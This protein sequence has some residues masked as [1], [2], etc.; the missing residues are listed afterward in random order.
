MPAIK[1]RDVNFLGLRDSILC[2]ECE[3]ISYNNT[4]KCL[5]CG[6]TAVLSLS[7]VLGG[8][9]QG[10]Q[11][12]RIVT[13][14]TQRNVVEFRGS[15]PVLRPPVPITGPWPS[16][17][18]A[19]STPVHSAMKLVVERGY[20]LSR[21][22]GIAIAAI[23]RGRMLCEA[24]QGELAPPLGAEIRAGISALS[25]RSRR[26]LRCDVAADDQRVDA[27]SCRA[28]GINS[29]VAAPIANLDR[30]FGL[31]TVVSPQPYAFNDRDVAIVQW[32]AGMMAVVF[33]G[34]PADLSFIARSTTRAELPGTA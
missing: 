10:E 15:A 18:V 28:V 34:A 22:G 23:R 12:A 19:G 9:L 25:L 5:A 32:L 27:A 31:M 24:R 6:S 33:T 29:I 16:A 20:C 14:A 30:V 4:S 26:T 2:S 8:S 3:L 13:E 17:D 1:P 21:S 11:R 7:R